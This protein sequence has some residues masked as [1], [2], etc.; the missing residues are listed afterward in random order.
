MPADALVLVVE[1]DDDPVIGGLGEEVAEELRGVPGLAVRSAGERDATLTLARMGDNEV[2]ARLLSDGTALWTITEDRSQPY[3]VTA[4]AGGVATAL[5]RSLPRRTATTREQEGFELYLEARHAMRHHW[6]VDV[7]R[8]LSL[9][10]A[11]AAKLP[12]DPRVRAT[13]VLVRVRDAFFE[14]GP[15]PSRFDELRADARDALRD[16]PDRV[17]AWEAAARAELYAGHTVEAAR[18]L[19]DATGRFPGSAPL[20]GLLGAL[21]GECGDLEGGLRRVEMARWLAPESE[22]DAVTHAYLLLLSG[23]HDEARSLLRSPVRGPTAR[24]LEE[25]RIA[26]WEGRMEAPV[27]THDV[28]PQLA[29]W[30]GGAA[31]VLATRSMPPGFAVAVDRYLAQPASPRFHAGLQQRLSEL[32]VRGGEAEHALELI[33]DASLGAL[34]DL[35]WF[36]HCPV[37]DE[38]RGDPRFV[39]A[40]A[41][42]AAT[43]EAVLA[44]LG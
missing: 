18:L 10:D 16:A 44:V 17:D 4:V 9:L 11:A 15:D 24:P 28:I 2:R 26:V 43:A 23:R 1:T 41:R 8:A 31:H 30:I 21:I 40:R 34:T 3:L 35:A 37:L 6:S 20:H 5:G 39:D 12:D 38:L 13:R 36:D 29:E 19:V 14:R 25:M 7:S 32:L 33:V 22:T 27:A 42:V